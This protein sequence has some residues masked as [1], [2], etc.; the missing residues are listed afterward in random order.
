MRAIRTEHGPDR[1]VCG[2]KHANSPTPPTTP[3]GISPH[4]PLTRVAN[5]SECD[6]S[7]LAIS[8]GD[9][10]GNAG[11]VE[12]ELNVCVEAGTTG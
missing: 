11:V 1:L 9:I 8:N 10:G 6:P 2:R 7:T 5:E 12:D 4:G 3:Y